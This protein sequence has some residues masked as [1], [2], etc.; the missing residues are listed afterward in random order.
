[1]PPNLNSKVY[2]LQSG[3][4]E[5]IRGGCSEEATL[6]GILRIA[7]EIYF[8]NPNS[9][10]VIQGILPYSKAGDGSLQHEIHGHPLSRERQKEFSLKSA[11]RYNSIWP[12]IQRINSELEK[13]C[14]LHKHLVFFDVSALFLGSMGNEYYKQKQ[15]HIILDLLFQGRTLTFDGYSVLGTVIQ[16]K[17][18]K[19]INDGDETND[20]EKKI[21]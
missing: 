5:L 8:S 3:V 7:D 15:Q 16:K 19:I 18:S 2:W 14:D 9:V 1:M 6:L 12:S 20:I 4:N 13:F 17:L 11:I 10:I 21:R